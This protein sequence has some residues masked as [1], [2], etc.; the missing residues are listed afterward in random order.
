MAVELGCSHWAVERAMRQLA[1]E[2]LLVSQGAGRR[3]RIVLSEGRAKFRTLRVMVLLY[4]ESDGKASYMIELL[5][6]LRAAGHNAVFAGKTMR[7]LGMNVKR[8]ARFAEEIKVDA[9]VVM[10]GSRDVLNWFATKDTPVFALFGRNAHCP[11]ASISLKKPEAM[12][13]LA[14]QL[15]DLGHRRIVI[16]AREERRKPTP[17][18]LEKIFL[19]RL[20]TRGIP[21][22]PVC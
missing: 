18:S 1:K 13:E 16:L 19:E 4:E 14:D 12:V 17:A 7:G 15:V 8:I 21:T 11:V 5:R 9:W 20:N 6:Q 22:G 10:A 3:R 2:G